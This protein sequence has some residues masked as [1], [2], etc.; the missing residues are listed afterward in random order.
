MEDNRKSSKH[1]WRTTRCNVDTVGSPSLISAH[2]GERM[3][4]LQRGFK[5]IYFNVMILRY[6]A[7]IIQYLLTFLFMVLPPRH[8]LALLA[9]VLHL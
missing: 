9:A 3:T 8:F 1:H 2:T 6:M 5:L 7:D 4:K